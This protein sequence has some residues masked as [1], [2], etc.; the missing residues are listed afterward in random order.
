[1]RRAA[2]AIIVLALAFASE[3]CANLNKGIA[4]SSAAQMLEKMDGVDSASVTY[5]SVEQSTRSDPVLDIKVRMKNDVTIADPAALAE[6]VARVGWSAGDEDPTGGMSVSITSFPQLE[7]GQALVDAGWSGVVYDPT[8]RDTFGLGYNRTTSRW[9]E[10][11]V[12]PPETL[13]RTP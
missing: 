13:V 1:M 6:Y 5:G 10:W 8:D 7:F 9:G 11:P 2:S 3:G 12:A 4:V